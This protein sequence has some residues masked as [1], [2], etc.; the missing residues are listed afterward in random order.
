MGRHSKAL[1][2]AIFDKDLTDH[3]SKE[4]DQLDFRS[5]YNPGTLNIFS[6]ASGFADGKASYGIICVCMDSIIQM[7]TFCLENSNNYEAEAL[8]IRLALFT[9]IHYSRM[10]GKINVFTDSLASLKVILNYE[11]IYTVPVRD[12][13]D[14]IIR[15]G[16]S[17]DP[18]GNKIYSYDRV[19]TDCIWAY[20]QLI[21]MPDY[22]IFSIY[23]MNSHKVDEKQNYNTLLVDQG[24]KNFTDNNFNYNALTREGFMYMAKYNGIIDYTVKMTLKEM[25]HRERRD[26]IF[27][28]CPV[29]FYPRKTPEEFILRGKDEVCFADT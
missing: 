19:F 25:I 12:N 13:D 22:T 3:K 1:K 23:H 9:A 8:G 26:K 16:L 7:N 17:K 20:N 29:H 21:N 11:D 27:S 5:L 2:D 6:D 4:Y 14:N 24:R 10:F 28:T 18:N 15:Y